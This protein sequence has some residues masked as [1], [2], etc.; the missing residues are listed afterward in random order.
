MKNFT[1]DTVEMITKN[2]ND[3]NNNND[4]NIGK[5]EE[6]AFCLS[7]LLASIDLHIT[8]Y[9]D[10]GVYCNCAFTEFVTER[11]WLK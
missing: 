2:K 4:C 10:F 6:K 8:Y 1:N 5:N 7:I 3:I 9:F 11:K